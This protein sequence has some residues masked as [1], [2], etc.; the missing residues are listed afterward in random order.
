MTQRDIDRLVVL[1]KAHKK[2]ITHKRAAAAHGGPIEGA[3]PFRELFG[4][5]NSRLRFRF[6]KSITFFT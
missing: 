6:G 5:V 2:L 1:H 4:T 3:G